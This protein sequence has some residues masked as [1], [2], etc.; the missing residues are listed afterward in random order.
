MNMDERMLY[1]HPDEFGDGIEAVEK[2]G[3]GSF[4]NKLPSLMKYMTKFMD[5]KSMG[6]A[7]PSAIM[8]YAAW[9]NVNG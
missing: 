7:M 8:V 5:L 9:S 4:A 6:E 2:Y 1:E 3:D